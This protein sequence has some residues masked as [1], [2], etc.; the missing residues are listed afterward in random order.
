LTVFKTSIPP[1]RGR[2]KSSR[3]SPGRGRDGLIAKIAT[4]VKKVQGCL[5]AGH[6]RWPVGKTN[7]RKIASNYLGVGRIILRQ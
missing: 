6:V 4:P 7:L 3:I 1:T 5:T 2:R